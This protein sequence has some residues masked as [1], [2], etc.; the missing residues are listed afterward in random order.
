[1]AGYTQLAITETAQSHKPFFNL[2][3]QIT[4]SKSNPGPVLVKKT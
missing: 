4:K 3:Q 2:H 1:M